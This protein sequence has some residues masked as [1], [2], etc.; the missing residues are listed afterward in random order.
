MIGERFDIVLFMGVLYHL[1][2]PLLA[3]DLIAEHAARDLLIYQSMQRGSA[4]M[5][6]VAGDYDFFRLTAGPVR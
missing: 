3:L 2:H 5:A 6:E 4:D 1:R